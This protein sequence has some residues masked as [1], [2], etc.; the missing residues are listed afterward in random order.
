MVRAK[1]FITDYFGLTGTWSATSIF[2]SSDLPAAVTTL[3]YTGLTMTDATLQWS[4]FTA[5][6]DKGY[7][8]T[9][10][11][12]TLYMDDCRNGSFANIL[13]QSTT[14]TSYQISSITPGSVCRF[15]MIVQNII[16]YGP[17]SDILTIMFAQV[18]DAP[19]APVYV[20]RSGGDSTIGLSPYITISWSQPYG[21]GGIPILGYMVEYSQDGGAYTVQYDG[22]TN[23]NLTMFMFQQLLAGSHYNFIVYAR[24][25]MGYSAASPSTM[26][27]AAT[28][29]PQMNPPTVGTIVPNGTSSTIQINWSAPS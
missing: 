28:F 20:D 13:S 26:I 15:R 5:N 1:N 17:Y 9:D 4:L 29:P 18:P 16:G 3:T 2:Y 21:T 19:L 10:P 23:A 25:A 12:Y 7:S 6:A 22:S 27:Y 8:V 11:V 24:N 14:A